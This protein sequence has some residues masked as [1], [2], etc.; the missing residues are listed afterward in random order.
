MDVSTAELTRRFA[1]MS[2]QELLRLV[3]S[4]DLT[5]LARRVATSTLN[6][7]GITPSSVPGDASDASE[8]ERIGELSDLEPTQELQTLTAR[9]QHLVEASLS[10]RSSG[11]PPTARN[12][13]APAQKGISSRILVLSIGVGLAVWLWIT[14]TH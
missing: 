7:R 10:A 9:E 13:V 8:A 14:L 3:R 5:P 1:K 2:D 12:L 6:S 4:G 11:L